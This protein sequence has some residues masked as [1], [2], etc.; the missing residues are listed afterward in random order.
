M[1]DDLIRRIRDRIGQCRQLAATTTDTWTKEVLLNMAE[2]GE[3]DVRQLEL[4]R[5]G[6]ASASAVDLDCSEPVQDAELR[7]EAEQ[8][9]HGSDA[10]QCQRSWIE[11]ASRHGVELPVFAYASDD[12]RVP[13]LMTDLSYDGCQLRLR[14]SFSEGEPLT[15]VHAHVGEITGQI[16]WTQEDKIGVRFTPTDCGTVD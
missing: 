1:P 2:E 3:A 10:E 16:Q 9:A 13:A 7:R 14:A 15:I 12:R 5:G 4:E 6:T 11:R 8:R